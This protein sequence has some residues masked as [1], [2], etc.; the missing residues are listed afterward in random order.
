MH[1]MRSG[2]PVC[3]TGLRSGTNACGLEQRA[4][5]APG[6]EHAGGIQAQLTG[7][8]KLPA[9]ARRGRRVDVG[10]GLDAPLLKK[11]GRAPSRSESAGVNTSV[12]SMAYARRHARIRGEA[13]CPRRRRQ[14]TG[15]APLY[16]RQ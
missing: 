11:W 5:G 10:E 2:L 9:C 7:D 3:T 12:A 1:E 8:K 14:C 4:D 6:D 16:V 15:R 13:G